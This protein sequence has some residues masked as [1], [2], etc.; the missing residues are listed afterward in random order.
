MP[1][2]TSN[3]RKKN[4]AHVIPKDNLVK[5]AKEMEKKLIRKRRSYNS[6]GAD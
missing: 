5:E 1:K 4:N 2:S 3:R 6:S